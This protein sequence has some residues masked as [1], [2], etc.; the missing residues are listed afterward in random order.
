MGNSQSS[1]TQRSSLKA[2]RAKRNASGNT[3]R[4]YRNNR[5]RSLSSRNDSKE[6]DF[7]LLGER[8]KDSGRRY[9]NRC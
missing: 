4:D 6:N 7:D 3:Y 2:R 9:K 5:E 1:E 8:N